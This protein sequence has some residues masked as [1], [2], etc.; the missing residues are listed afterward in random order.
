MWVF[1]II[2]VVILSFLDNKE[3]QNKIDEVAKA[4]LKRKL[5]HSRGNV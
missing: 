5:A 3:E 2:G 1:I 4:R